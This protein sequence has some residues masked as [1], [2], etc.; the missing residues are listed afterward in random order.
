MTF[1]DQIEENKWI[2]ILNSLVCLVLHFGLEFITSMVSLSVC[3]ICVVHSCNTFY[4]FACMLFDNFD[5]CI[6]FYVATPME[7]AIATF[8]DNNFL[9]IV[10]TTTT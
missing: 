3:G 7:F 8:F 9:G 2:S 5:T 10:A 1:H 6:T 4:L